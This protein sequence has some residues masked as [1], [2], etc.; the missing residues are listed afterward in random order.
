MSL[1]PVWKWWGNLRVQ[2]FKKYAS[3]GVEMRPVLYDDL[4][5]DE[6]EVVYL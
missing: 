1:S 6:Q 5:V 4:P 2:L 3:E